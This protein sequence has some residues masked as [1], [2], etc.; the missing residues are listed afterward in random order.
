MENADVTQEELLD[1]IAAILAPP[2]VPE[3]AFTAADMAER[4]GTTIRK[5][6]QRLDYKA[7][8][9]D[10]VKKIKIGNRAYYRMIEDVD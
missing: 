10:G 8:K 3:D 4:W 6:R 9:K 5:A 7:E 2:E 1:E